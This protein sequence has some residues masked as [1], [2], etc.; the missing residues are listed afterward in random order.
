MSKSACLGKQVSSVGGWQESIVAS[1]DPRGPRWNLKQSVKVKHD[2]FEW[3]DS[4]IDLAPILWYAM[5]GSRPF[6]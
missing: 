2:D 5:A 6:A 3:A 1:Q 4:E